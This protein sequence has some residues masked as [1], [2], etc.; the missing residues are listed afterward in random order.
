MGE[1]PIS[2]PIGMATMEIAMPTARGKA[3]ALIASHTEP[4]CTAVQKAST[5]S[6]GLG[7]TTGLGSLTATASCQM[8][9]KATRLTV[10]GRCDVSRFR[11]G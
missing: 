6:P 3:L 2:R 1:S 11:Q 4:S 9:M 10:P 8:P 5:T 7:S